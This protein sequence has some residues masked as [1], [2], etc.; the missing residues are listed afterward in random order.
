MTPLKER[1]RRENIPLHEYGSGIRCRLI[2]KDYIAAIKRFYEPERELNFDEPID[3]GRY[4]RQW[5]MTVPVGHSNGKDM[6]VFFEATRP[7]IKAKLSPDLREFRIFKFMIY[8]R[9]KLYKEKLDGT[10]DYVEPLFHPGNQLV[11]RD[12]NELEDLLNTSFDQI[13]EAIEK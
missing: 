6:N 13:N 12:S 1:I 10:V 4:L 8:L 3:G 5:T 11:L 7:K 9:I 2:K